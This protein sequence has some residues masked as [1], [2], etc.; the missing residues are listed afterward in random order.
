MAGKFWQKFNHH[1]VVKKFHAFL[2]T[3]LE[4]ENRTYDIF[5]F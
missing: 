4:L 3:G 2:I 1:P 5:K